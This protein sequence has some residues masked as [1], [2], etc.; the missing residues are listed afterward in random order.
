MT[1]SRESVGSGGIIAA[2]PPP[3]GGAPLLEPGQ[4][5]RRELGDRRVARQ[6]PGAG[7]LRVQPAQ[8]P[9]VGD[10]LRQLLLLAGDLGGPARVGVERRRRHLGVEFVQAPLKRG[11][12][13]EGVHAGQRRAGA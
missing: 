6:G 5:L 3:Q 4:L 13:R 1:V 11:D 7:D 12:V 9:V 2:G 10:Q 8:R